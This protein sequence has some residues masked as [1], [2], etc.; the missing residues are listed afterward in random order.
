MDIL[1]IIAILAAAVFLLAIPTVAY[2][3]WIR[4][5]A[6]ESPEQSSNQR[7]HEAEALTRIDQI[8]G[9]FF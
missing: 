3:L 1:G 7:S 8:N 6:L 2:R 9:T 5:S 4:R